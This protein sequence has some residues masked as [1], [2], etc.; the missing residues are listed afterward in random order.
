MTTRDFWKSAG[1]HLLERG[2]E[3]WLQV[4]PQFLRAYYTRPE[5]HPLDTSCA[6]EIRL[7][8]DL[9]ADPMMPVEAARLAAIADA[10]AADNYRAVLA[11][12]DVLMRAG[13][14]EGAYVRL[15]R[16]SA[17]AI[18]PVFIDQMVHVI[19]RNILSDC[20]D[21]IRLRAGELFFREQ[22][23]TTDGGRLMLADEEIVEMH[24]RAGKETGLGQ[25]LAETGTPM[26]KVELDVLDEDN[27]AIYWL[28]SD[29][30]DTVIDFRFGQPAPDAFARVI[31]SWLRHLLKLEVRVEPRPRV[32]DRDWRWHI[33]LDREGTRILNALY[34]GRTPPLEEMARI[35]GLFRMRIDDERMVLERVKGKPIYLGLAMD[36]R[37]RVKM[38]PQNLLTNLPLVTAA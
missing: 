19:L 35:V 18:P 17:I 38:K 27:K 37:S 23:V 16:Q 25:L 9:M 20:E 10:E 12:R 1:M 36:A 33:G 3:G 22:S 4:T 7:H 32:E 6:E 34:E 26:R 28:R 13:T 24:A 30:F 14:I 15:M 31:E 8:D 5:V 2:P 21:P 11:Y 29:R